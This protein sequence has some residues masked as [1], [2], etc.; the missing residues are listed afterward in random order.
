MSR[1]QSKAHGPSME[2]SDMQQRTW[3]ELAVGVFFLQLYTKFS[4][5]V[6]LLNM[7]FVHLEHKKI[8]FWIYSRHLNDIRTCSTLYKSENKT[9]YFTFFTQYRHSFMICCIKLSY[10]HFHK[11][12]LFFGAY[13]YFFSQSHISY[14]KYCHRLQNFYELI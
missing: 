7:E 2:H 6:I 13:S 1:F 5:N 4:T 12:S 11:K 9:N 10:S 3:S 14:M 8:S